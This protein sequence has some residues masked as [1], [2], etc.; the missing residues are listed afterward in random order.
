MKLV[1]QRSALVALTAA[2]VLAVSQASGY[3]AS[4]AAAPKTASQNAL[5]NTANSLEISPLRTDLTIQPG[6]SKSVTVRITNLTD[7]AVSLDPIENDFIAG[8]ENGTPAIILDQNSYAP[9]HSLKR[10]M[11]P[12][13]N[14]T[15]GPKATKAVN[16]QINVPPG[17]QPGGYFGALRFAPT[18]QSGL[19]ISLNSSVASLILMTVPG[20]TLEKLTLT[21]FDVQQNGNAA[22][23]FRTP[24]NLSLLVRFRNDG[25]LQEAPF[26][27]VVVQ[28]GKKVLYTYNFNQQDPKQ[29]ILP[30]SARRWEVPLKNLGKFGKYTIS[31]TFGYGNGESI[32]ISKSVWI[33]PTTYIIAAI[34]IIVILILLIVGIR[35][36]LKSY[37]RRVLRG[38][39][40]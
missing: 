22:S 23:N 9:T 29:E 30:D 18:S 28:K 32:D 39:R 2:A 11:M 16:L 24:N 35:L 26:G 13:P 25:N 4:A 36:F 12:L 3:I 1:K 38:A 33:I 20:P 40:R 6:T 15:L 14:F 7:G 31:G 34:A 17:A 21:N 37:R 10:F 19:P 5:K 27:Q 8:D